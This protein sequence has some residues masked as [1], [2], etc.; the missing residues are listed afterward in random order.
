MNL[1]RQ[2]P[3]N[4]TGYPGFGGEF[5]LESVNGSTSLSDFRGEVVVLYFGFASCPDVCPATSGKVRAALA[6]LPL[7][8]RDRVNV[9]VVTLDPERDTAERV[10]AYAASF[11]KEFI[12]LTGTGDAIDVVARNYG[13]LHQK[14]ELPDSAP[15]Y[16]IDHNSNT[17]VIGVDG[18]VRHIVSHGSEV[19]EY[20]D[21]IRDAITDA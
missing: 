9:V 3:S 10:G 6:E 5:T 11:G 1:W 7:A 4:T 17:F 13:V 16:T 2:G 12:G 14:V 20:R 18:V 19:A 21:R 8:E 15:G